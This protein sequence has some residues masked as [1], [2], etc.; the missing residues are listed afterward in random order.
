MHMLCFTLCMNHEPHENAKYSIF[1]GFCVFSVFRD[2]FAA[3]AGNHG[4]AGEVKF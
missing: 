1:F 3:H 2:F 4:R